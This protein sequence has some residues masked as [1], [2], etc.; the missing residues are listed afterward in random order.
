MK[1]EKRDLERVSVSVL[2]HPHTRSDVLFPPEK[3]ET[4]IG[5][6]AA[7]AGVYSIRYT[8]TRFSIVSKFP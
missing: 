1:E 7:A 8:I 4:R 2:I 5:M 6:P 3:G